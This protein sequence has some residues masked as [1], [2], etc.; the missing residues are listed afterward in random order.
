MEHVGVGVGAGAGSKAGLD[1][2]CCLGY[3]RAAAKKSGYVKSVEIR[4]QSP[5][6]DLRSVICAPR[7]RV[8]PLH[9]IRA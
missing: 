6:S 5:I 4:I 7:N 9:G 1:V 3:V 2:E 8:I